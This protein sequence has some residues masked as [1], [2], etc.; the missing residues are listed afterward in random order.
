MITQLYTRKNGC[1]VMKTTIELIDKETKENNITK[2]HEIQNYFCSDEN[3]MIWVRL[4]SL[5]KVKECGSGWGIVFYLSLMGVG[6][7][8]V[9]FWNFKSVI[10]AGLILLLFLSIFLFSVFKFIFIFIREYEIRRLGK[11]NDEEMI[12]YE[13]YNEDPV[14]KTVVAATM[15]GHQMNLIKADSQ[16]NHKY[17]RNLKSDWRILDEKTNRRRFWGEVSKIS[18]DARVI[19][20]K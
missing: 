18:F 1:E 7:T 19:Y 4:K 17:Y 8:R 12:V 16:R 9:R 10:D 15:K 20:L 11:Y 5:E 14:E 2:T 6:I 3:V 13:L